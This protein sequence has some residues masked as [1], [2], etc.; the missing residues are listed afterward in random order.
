MNLYQTF[1]DW[2]SLWMIPT[3]FSPSISITNHECWLVLHL[4]NLSSHNIYLKSSPLIGYLKNQKKWK[5]F[6]NISFFRYN[7]K[8]S[9]LLSYRG[10]LFC[11]KLPSIFFTFLNHFSYIFWIYMEFIIIRNHPPFIGFGLFNFV[12]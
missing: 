9:S 3:S 8:L 5:R 6:P 4:S 7:R 12:I 2:I 11:N 1:F 10:I